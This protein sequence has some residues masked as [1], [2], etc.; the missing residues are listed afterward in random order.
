MSE[1][2]IQ[3]G[4]DRAGS[5]IVAAV[6]SAWDQI[7]RRH[8]QVPDVVVTFGA[9]TIG[10]TPG[11]VRLGHFAAQR[12]AADPGATETPMHELFI[13]GEGLTR[14]SVCL[15]G[16]LLHEAAHA[17]AHARG[18]KDTSRQGRYHNTRFK[19]VAEEM[20]VHVAQVG[21]IGWSA[22]TVPEATLEEYATE[23][24]ELGLAIRAYRRGEW[25]GMVRTG[26]DNGAD[27]D[28]QGDGETDGDEREAK[29]RRNGVVAVCACDKPRRI[30]VAW[31]VWESGPI[32]CGV[33]GIDFHDPDCTDH[34]EDA[35]YD[36]SNKREAGE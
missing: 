18:I 28:G 35:D 20:G 4:T 11:T 14:G 24:V 15:L 10:S 1:N 27:S 31:S 36:N 16:T 21:A 12:W 7:Q 34:T 2:S 30:R 25:G 13:G 23:V 3:N 19:T 8:P 33:C 26:P 5:V 22:T 29:K 32:G 6:E 17:L 9:G